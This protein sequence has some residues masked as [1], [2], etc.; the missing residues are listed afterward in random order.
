M[1]GAV[2]IGVAIIVAGFRSLDN[3][4]TDFNRI[5]DNALGAPDQIF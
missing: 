2:V 1:I 4:E 5:V 3:I